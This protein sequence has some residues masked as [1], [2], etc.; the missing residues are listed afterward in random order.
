MHRT[1][2]D[3]INI[4]LYQPTYTAAAAYEESK[5][6]F[7]GVGKQNKELKATTAAEF[8]IHKAPLSW[9]VVTLSRRFHSNP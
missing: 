7:R 4:L 5:R 6:L 2:W 9:L 3:N 1:V 8:P